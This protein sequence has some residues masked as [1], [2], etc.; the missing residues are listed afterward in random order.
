MPDAK[1]DSTLARPLADLVG[2]TVADRYRIVRLLGRGGTG[3]VYEA[4]PLEGGAPVAV[5]ALLPGAPDAP[6][7]AER[8]RREA[9]AAAAGLLD[10]PNIV[11]I[12]ELAGER[13]ELYLVME[14]LRGHSVA[15]ELSAGPLAARRTLVI[16]RQVLEALG[17]AHARGAIHRDVKP[18][19]LFLTSAGEPGRQYERVKLLDF[20]L[21]KLVGAAA[22]EAGP[23]APTRD[24]TIAGTPAYMAPEQALGREV[25]GR[26]DLYALGIAIFEMLTGRVPFRSP[27]PVTLVRMQ[28]QVPAPTLAAS[29]PG[30]PWCTPELER[31]VARALAKRPDERYA[32]AAEMTAALDA[33]FGSL[34]HLPAGA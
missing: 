10:H 20:G 34:D 25:D 7:I 3:A 30:R 27:D 24:G 1:A 14:L 22:A 11:E 18:D 29:A 4:E 33:A 31:L 26:A 16:A 5:K 8:F 32:D 21:V 2:R 9:A 15:G 6:L 17:H 23:G 19:H 28:A 13:D 12:R